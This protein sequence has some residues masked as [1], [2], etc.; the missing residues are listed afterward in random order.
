MNLTSKKASVLIS[1]LTAIAFSRTMF[2]F[3]ND[4]EGPNLLIVLV[5][6]AVV[7]TASSLIVHFATPSVFGLKRILLVI[8]V[9]IVV[10]GVLYFFLN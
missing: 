7:Y 9:Q 1:G 6:A 5:M 2:V 4:P 10:L 8:F 3:I